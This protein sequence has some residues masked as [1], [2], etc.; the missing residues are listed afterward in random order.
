MDA[1][2]TPPVRR[3]L[4][5]A[6]AL[7]ISALAL[8]PLDGPL[9]EAAIALRERLGGDLR[10]F[11]ET[12][13]QFGDL[14]SMLFV[15]LLVWLLDPPRR[16]ALGRLALAAFLTFAVVQALKILI[17]RPRP[18]FHEPLTFLG[19]LGTYEINAEVGPRH[20]WEIASGI[21]SDLWSMP[22][23][24]TAFAVVLGLFLAWLYPRLRP[25]VWVL[26][27]LVACAR[28]L[29]GAHYPSDVL[30][31][32][33]VALFI[34]VRVYRPPMPDEPKPPE[35]EMP[36]R[37]RRSLHRF[38][39]VLAVLGVLAGASA[40]LWHKVVRH[41]LYPRNFG[42]VVEGRI[43]RS[44][45]L[46]DTAT[47]S[48]VRDRHLRT[49]VDLG[50]FDPDSPREAHT[51]ELAQQLGVRRIRLN[52]IGDGTGDPNDYVTALRIMSDPDAQPVLVQC[53]AGSERT[54]VAVMLYRNLFEGVPIQKAYEET[55]RYKHDR[56]DWTMLA[57]V[58]DW[59]DAIA[60]ALRTGEPIPYP[61]AE[62]GTSSDENQDAAPSASDGD[63][64]G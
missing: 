38:I 17:G 31:G 6:I 46:T 23:S 57:Y 16:R 1:D 48:L 18:R 30:M 49:I 26:I 10:R 58:A 53:G 33:G 24:H 7:C 36:R 4:L 19:P 43:Y 28:A 50:A 20:A 13:Q 62:S 5:L 59:K 64:A 25:L 54:G 37:P 12:W 41:H 11:I 63:S 51:R 3:P 47:R 9:S 34:C 22:S 21:S 14:S 60:R 55:F 61:P 52:L 42:V 2:Y 40:V 32:A 35:S 45:R 8:I 44:G 15:A 39:A 29:L 27:A 56:D